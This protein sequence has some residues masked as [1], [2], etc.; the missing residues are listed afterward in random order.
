MIFEHFVIFFTLVMHISGDGQNHLGHCL[1][2]IILRHFTSEPTC[3]FSYQSPEDTPRKTNF[4]LQ[5][6]DIR[7]LIATEDS[8]PDSILMDLNEACEKILIVCNHEYENNVMIEESKD[9]HG[10]Y[11]LFH[12]NGNVVQDI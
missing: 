6:E 10:S 3:V 2:N 8:I 11:I 12:Q 4:M 1:H 7:L 9:K 5:N